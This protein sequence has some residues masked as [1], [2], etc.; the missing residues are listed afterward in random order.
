MI[1]G[2]FLHLGRLLVPN[3][4]LDAAFLA[5]GRKDYS[6]NRMCSED[7]MQGRRWQVLA[8]SPSLQAADL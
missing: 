7:E 3:P 2:V 4:N 1:V 8:P 6:V 5:E